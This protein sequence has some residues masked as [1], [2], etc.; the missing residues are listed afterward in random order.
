MHAV[1]KLTEAMQVIVDGSAKAIE[2]LVSLHRLNNVVE[3]LD[4]GFANLLQIVRRNAGNTFL[5]V[6]LRTINYLFDRTARIVQIG[7]ICEVQSHLLLPLCDLPL[8]AWCKW[9]GSRWQ[10]P[11]P[12]RAWPTPRIVFRHPAR[13]HEGGLFS[14]R[15]VLTGPGVKV[16]GAD[17]QHR[18]DLGQR[19]GE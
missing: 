11:W 15:L 18:L 5:R 2:K 17:T 8:H 14:D 10:Q 13:T 12:F 3:A 4:F 16:K 9:R 1:A 7:R 19:V 6:I